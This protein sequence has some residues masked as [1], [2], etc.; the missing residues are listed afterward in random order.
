[1]P[2]TPSVSGRTTIVGIIGDPVAHSRSPAMHNAAFRALGL[3]WI[4]VPFHVHPAGVR[5]AI[6][7]VRALR[8]AG[9]NVTVPHKEAVL[10]HLDSLSDAAQQI[11]AV[12]TIVNRDGTL[13]GENT[14]RIGFIRALRHTGAAVRN[15]HAI[16]I[17]AGGS[18]CAVLA[19]LAEAGAARVT[20]ANRT[21]ARARA[22]MRRFADVIPTTATG[23]EALTDRARLADAAVVINATS[24]GLSG[25]PFPSLAYPATPPECLFFDLLY[26]RDTEF[27]R[28]AKRARRPVLDGSEMLVQQGACA[29]GLWTGRRA[30]LAV[31]REALCHDTQSV[32]RKS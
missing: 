31:M 3:D 9:L 21:V 2:R 17:G 4:Y 30:P 19:G 18:A 13:H 22:L 32:Q 12:N 14:D 6:R 11:G 20:L 8:L 25:G 10:G 24:V 28:R 15:R 5:D 26:G 7:A 27:L 23:L 16:V 29:F 1:M